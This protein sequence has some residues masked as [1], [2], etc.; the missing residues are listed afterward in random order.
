VHELAE[1]SNFF[2]L[3][4]FAD[5]NLKPFIYGKNRMNIFLLSFLT[6]KSFFSASKFGVKKL[7]PA[8]LDP[9]LQLQDL[10][11]GVSFASGG[12]GYDPLT[13]QLAVNN[14]V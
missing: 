3:R 10:L 9:N 14:Y 12:A 11:T 5:C 1:T 6:K 13:S 7:L 4:L 8:S 2:I